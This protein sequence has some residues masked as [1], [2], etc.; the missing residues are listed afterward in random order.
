MTWKSITIVLAVAHSLSGA[1]P[2]SVK[3]PWEWTVEERLAARFNSSARKDRVARAAQGE[4][5]VRIATAAHD[6]PSRFDSLHGRVHPELLLPTEVFGS[7]VRAAFTLDDAAAEEFR[8]D[9]AGKARQFGMPPSLLRD[10]ATV[11][12]EYAGVEAR[13]KQ[14]RD[15]LLTSSG[16]DLQEGL[17]TLRRLES[18]ACKAR[19]LALSELRSRYP[20]FDRYLYGAIAPNVFFEVYEVQHAD[21]LR[22]NERGCFGGEL[23]AAQLQ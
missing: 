19:F 2:T 5:N 9:A 17:A 13:I 14:T 15:R 21:E 16:K 8:K 12:A 7:F 22:R 11:S 6:E 3:E 18:E 20:G 10:V 1:P 23:K 4:R